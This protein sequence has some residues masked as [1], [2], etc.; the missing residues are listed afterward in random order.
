MNRLAGHMRKVAIAVLAGAFVAAGSVVTYAAMTLNP[1]YEWYTSAT[2][3][4]DDPYVINSR[5]QFAG[6]INLVNG[7]ADV[8][9]NSSTAAVCDDFSGKIVTLGANINFA[10][11]ELNPAGGCDSHAFNGTFDGAGYTLNGFKLAAADGQTSNIGLIGAAGPQSVIKNV[12]IGS[13][14]KLTVS[15]DEGVNENL[16]CIGMLVGFSEGTV[17]DC[18]NAGSVTVTSDADGVENNMVRIKDVGGLIGI[19]KGDIT[20]CSNSGAVTVTETGDARNSNETELVVY[21]GGVVGCSGDED[22]SLVKDSGNACGT[23]SYCTNSGTVKVDTPAKVSD[24]LYSTVYVDGDFIGG[25]VGYSRGSVQYCTNSGYINS[26][27]G[28]D[29]GGVVGGLRAALSTNAYNGGMSESDEGSADNYIRLFACSNTGNVAGYVSLG[30]IA[31]RVGSY[32]E[33][34]GCM[35]GDPSITSTDKQNWVAGIRPNKPCPGG[36]VGASYSDVSF[37]V[38]YGNVASCSWDFDAQEWLGDKA[39]YYAS[40]IVAALHYYSKDGVITSYMPSVYSCIN[41]GGVSAT[42]NMRQRNIVG[43]AEEGYAYDN[44]AATGMCY[45][46]TMTYENAS[47][48]NLALKPS[49]IKANDT[50]K[51]TDASRTDST[52][53]N[54]P[55][56]ESAVGK[57]VLEILNSHA[58]ANGWSVFWNASDGT[59]YPTLSVFGGGAENSISG[60]TATLL[61][62]AP[63]T[64]VN[65]STPTFS[66]SLDGKTL[67]QNV[68]FRVEAQD[69]AIEMSAAGETPYTA[70]LV[71][72]GQYSGTLSGK[73]GIGKLDLSTCTVKIDPVEFD[74]KPHS[75]TASTLSVKNAAGVTVDPEQ[76]TFAFGTASSEWA[77]AA[78]VD[79]VPVNAGVYDVV[80]TAKSGSETVEGSV[81]GNFVISKVSLIYSVDDRKDNPEKFAESAHATTVNAGTAYEAEWQSFRALKVNGA[82]SETT[83]EE[84]ATVFPY[85]GHVIIPTV[86]ATYKGKTLG[87][88]Y[89]VSGAIAGLDANDF[90]VDDYDNQLAVSIG[91]SELDGAG[92]NIDNI[93]NPDEKVVGGIIIKARMGDNS[94]V[95]NFTSYDAMEF[96]IDPSIKANLKDATVSLE[97]ETYTYEE[98]TACEPK[99]SVAVLGSLLDEGTDYVVEYS[100]N[101]KPGTATYTVKPGSNGIFEGSYT[102]TFQIVDAAPY[103]LTYEYSAADK[104]ATVTGVVYNGT[105]SSFEVEIPATVEFDGETYTVT[106]IADSAFKADADA[107]NDAAKISKVTIPATVQTIGK[108]AFGADSTS[109]KRL[110]E[111]VVFDDIDNSQLTTIGD[112]AFKGCNLLKEFTFPKNVATIE[113]RAFYLASTNALRKLTFMTQDASLP[114][115]VSTT[116]TFGNVGAK[117]NV[118][119]YAYSSATAVKA[120]IDANASTTAGAN[121]GRRFVYVE[122]EPPAQFSVTVDVT[123]VEAYGEKSLVTATVENAVGDVTYT[124]QARG[125]DTWRDMQKCADGNICKAGVNAAT[126][127]FDWRCIATDSAGNEAVCEFKL[128]L[129]E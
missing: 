58:E 41:L 23:V 44:F 57:T 50:I 126:I 94:T 72:I 101:T 18:S 112:S 33:V 76:Y 127:N 105:K 49:R 109:N 97:S 116:L 7:T 27:H 85:T 114:N 40:G 9:A 5:Q 69:G 71:G 17:T 19:C 54:I 80:V 10:N 12:S 56:D 92:T 61:K 14:A 123:P 121:A 16:G 88:Y 8:D 82:S 113:G 124:W 83:G 55:V 45:N 79:G 90:A 39:G 99:P 98:G 93:G 67:T 73:Y 20:N 77:D 129:K 65:G 42:D 119:V 122:M 15:L 100:N 103:T 63:Y 29:L 62:D 120:L 89:N 32:C 4:A 75:P 25:V 13:G 128:A 28:S 26:E 111:E 64:G 22:K 95:A 117:E 51:K 37:C 86:T 70:T 35:N 60:G 66:I 118:D 11:A 68:D 21:V 104:T 125:K 24:G 1:N 43:T 53:E 84:I 91:G 34:S 87:V 38:N 106:S 6:F 108:L 96:Y 30:G 46:D 102:G 48:V 115:E 78:A 74:Y 81:S 107:T 36:I 31:G 3:T 59:T 110:L 52:G 2:G 47:G